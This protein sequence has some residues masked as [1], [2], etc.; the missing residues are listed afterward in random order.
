[1]PRDHEISIERNHEI[2]TEALQTLRPS[3]SSHFRNVR[4]L[5]QEKCPGSSSHLR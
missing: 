5:P 4:F 3:V 1:M 2:L